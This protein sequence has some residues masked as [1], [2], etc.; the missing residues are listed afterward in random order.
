MRFILIDRILEVKR[1]KNIT[2]IKNVT[3]SDDLFIDHFPG[4]PIYPGA[5]VL[6]S[7]CQT[8]GALI[9]ISYDFQCK[10]IVFMIENAKYR[11]YIRP[12]DQVILKAEIISTKENYV[13]V[14]ARAL[15]GDSTRVSAMLVFT[16]V[17]MNDF[18]DE[19]LR[20]LSEILYEMWLEGRSGS[21]KEKKES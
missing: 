4:N 3:L 9:E 14:K 7:L 15:V 18:C 1:N 2:A 16:L 12:G 19:R 10:A 13:R 21:K 11:E 5:L 8:G 6:E 20:F 17:N